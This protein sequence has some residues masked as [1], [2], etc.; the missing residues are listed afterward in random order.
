MFE[1]SYIVLAFIRG[2]DLPPLPGGEK[3]CRWGA[4]IPHVGDTRYHKFGEVRDLVC[5]LVGHLP[6][7][8]V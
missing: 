7:E 2:C 8:W 1:L 3:A 6:N 4:H 5:D